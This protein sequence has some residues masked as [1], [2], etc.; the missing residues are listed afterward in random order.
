MSEALDPVP[1]APA[2]RLALGLRE[3]DT[4]VV[5]A[6]L[7]VGVY[8]ALSA[9]GV[10]IDPHTTSRKA[11]E[12][13]GVTGPV[14]LI[15]GAF[16]AW[17]AGA[18]VVEMFSLTAAPRNRAPLAAALFYVENAAPFV[19][20]LECFISIVSALLAYSAAAAGPQAQSA[21]IANIAVALGASAAGCFIALCA[22][23]LKTVVM[24]RDGGA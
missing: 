20:L 3:V 14:F 11:A 7:A 13:L 22:H 10:Q 21:M 5:T 1:A 8:L 9:I 24:Y 18:L 16:L 19:G 23:S 4:L 6:M 12:F 15:A 17:V 2:G